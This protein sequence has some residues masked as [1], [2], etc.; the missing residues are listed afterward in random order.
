[1]LA[2]ARRLIIKKLFMNEEEL[3][4]NIVLYYSKLSKRAQEYF[5]SMTWLEILA[6]IALRYFLNDWQK[7]ELGTETTLILLGIID[8]NEYRE[9]LERELALSEDSFNSI[10]KEVEEKILKPVMED[11]EQALKI[12]TLEAETAVKEQLLENR[13]SADWTKNV[14][15]ILSGGDSSVFAPQVPEQNKGSLAG[16]QPDRSNARRQMEN[17]KNRLK[18]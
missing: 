9:N 6:G 11:L 15:F 16:S 17:L 13:F 7:E 5:S 4:K 3:Q 18:I 10:F 12:N 14:D 2:P 8:K 1:M